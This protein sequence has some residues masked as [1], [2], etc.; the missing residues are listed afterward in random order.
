M[1]SPLTLAAGSIA[2]C[3]VR[4]I[5]SSRAPSR[6]KSRRFSEW[7]GHAGYPNAGRIPR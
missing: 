5:P 4:S 6:S 3:S 2:Q 1:Y 7:S